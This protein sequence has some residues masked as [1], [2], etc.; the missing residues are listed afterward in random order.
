MVWLNSCHNLV[1]VLENI[2]A[3]GRGSIWT[4]EKGHK[5]GEHEIVPKAKKKTSDTED[6]QQCA[7][8]RL[9]ELKKRHST[10]NLFN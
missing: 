7:Q 9:E 5:V 8:A 6:K 1:V 3:K 4:V 2:N 10:K